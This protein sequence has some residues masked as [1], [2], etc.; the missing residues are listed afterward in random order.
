MTYLNTQ[1][2]KQRLTMSVKIQIEVPSIVVVDRVIVKIEQ[3]RTIISVQ[4][5]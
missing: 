3:L 1:V 2:D 4:R 5:K